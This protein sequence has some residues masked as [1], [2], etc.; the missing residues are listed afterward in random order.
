MKENSGAKG[1]YVKGEMS[2]DQQSQ[3]KEETSFIHSIIHSLIHSS[4][5]VMWMKKDSKPYFHC[6][7]GGGWPIHWGVVRVTPELFKCGNL[8]LFVLGIFRIGTI[9]LTLV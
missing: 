5:Y 2:R 1:I 6:S 3:V 9:V 4:I 8:F 7:L